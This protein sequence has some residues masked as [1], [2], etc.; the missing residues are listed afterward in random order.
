MT[1]NPVKA[2]ISQISGGSD[3]STIPSPYLP[4]PI[5]SSVFSTAWQT[6]R[7]QWGA[8]SKPSERSWLNQPFAPLNFGLLLT[9]ARQEAVN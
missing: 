7:A 2:D 1:P 6:Y 4:F 8:G 3:R 9:L 5:I